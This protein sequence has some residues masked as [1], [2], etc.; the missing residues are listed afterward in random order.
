MVLY[1]NFFYDP[2]ES[3]F[4]EVIQTCGTKLVITFLDEDDFI[5]N[6]QFEMLRDDNVSVLANS[7]N[8]E[9]KIYNLLINVLVNFIY[10]QL[11]NE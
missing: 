6:V 7:C 8:N 5:K 9:N 3:S 11:I 4:L 1:Y 10:I 2:Q